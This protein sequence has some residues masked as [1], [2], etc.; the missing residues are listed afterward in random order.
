MKTKKKT[1]VSGNEVTNTM[2]NAMVNKLNL[3]GASQEGE[4]Q[5]SQETPRKS[6]SG[7]ESFRKEE[8]DMDAGDHSHKNANA[9]MSESLYLS[10]NDQAHKGEQNQVYLDQQTLEQQQMNEQQQ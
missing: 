4:S 10:A 7:M 5:E 1:V 6:D 9:N 3:G 2:A 8:E